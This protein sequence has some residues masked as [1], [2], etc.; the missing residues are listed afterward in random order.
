[1]TSLRMPVVSAVVPRFDMDAEGRPV[2][3]SRL[4]FALYKYMR[5]LDRGVNIYVLSDGTVVTDLPVT[6]SDASLSS[7]AVPYPLT[8]YGTTTPGTVI[9]PPEGAEGGPF[10]PPP[11][12]AAVQDNITNSPT[13]QYTEY[14]RGPTGDGTA[15]VKYYFLGGHGPY[16]NLSANLVAILTAAKFDNYLF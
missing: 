13:G 10:G 12:Y 9:G 4:Q 7:T 8:M 2:P 5:P 15:Y 16:T 6:L 11:P 14:H 3:T 1:M